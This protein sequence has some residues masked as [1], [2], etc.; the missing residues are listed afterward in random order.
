MKDL[1]KKLLIDQLDEKFQNL[2]GFDKNII[3]SNGWIYSTRT[4]L[5]MSLKQLGKRMKKAPQS[6]KEIEEREKNKSI[7]LKGLNDVAEALS[8]QLVY[9][10]VPKN[11]SLQKM[12]E[13]RAYEVAKEIVLRTSHSMGLED[14]QNRD[15]RLKKAIKDR[16]EKIIQEVPKFLWD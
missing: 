10:F 15:E 3:P 14:Q 12:I 7:T 16:A 2:K 4:A 11:D 5:N 6:I 8:M 9:A 13:N 1:K